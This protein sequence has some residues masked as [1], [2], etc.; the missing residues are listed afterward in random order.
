[1]V[2]LLTWVTPQVHISTSSHNY[3][4]IMAPNS[5]VLTK[6]KIYFQYSNELKYIRKRSEIF[7]FKF[8][9]VRVLSSMTNIIN[10][11]ILKYF[12]GI[13]KF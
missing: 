5:V 9:I 12:I 11:L 8:G 6:I 10:H 4:G 3:I 2:I 1:M 13:K 7:I